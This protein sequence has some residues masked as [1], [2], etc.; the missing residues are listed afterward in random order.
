MLGLLKHVSCV[1]Y[2]DE[3][4]YMLQVHH[5]LI[6]IVEAYIAR[7]PVLREEAE[8]DFFLSFLVAGG[9][10]QPKFKQ[11]VVDL[12]GILGAHLLCSEPYFQ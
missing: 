3:Q 11:A 8:M 9:V 5:K 1:A 2:D 7:F 4:H 12:L 6:K 10:H